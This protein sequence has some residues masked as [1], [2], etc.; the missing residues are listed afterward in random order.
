MSNRS[1]EAHA[2]EVQSCDLCIIGA[3]IAGLNALFVASQY[4]KKTDRVVIID[5]NSGPGGMWNDVY[6]Y[7][8]LHAPHPGFTVGDIEW[9]LPKPT[10]YLATGAEVKAHLA[11]CLDVMRAKVNLEELFGHTVTAC[12]E[13][14]T[15]RGTVVRIQY[16]PNDGLGSPARHRG[17]EGH[18]G[19]RVR[20]SVARAAAS[21]Q[22][23]CGLEHAA[24][25]GPEWRT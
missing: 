3:G 25:L 10:H 19:I 2:Q 24:A 6:D 11:H 9:T 16:H 15:N 18:Q 21:D 13:V 4:L 17:K 23:E 7:C 1:A 14:S 20:R 12:D 5:R 8:Q 22:P